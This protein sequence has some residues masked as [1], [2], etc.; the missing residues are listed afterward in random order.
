MA[1]MGASGN[2]EWKIKLGSD[3]LIALRNIE[4]C[5]D[6]TQILPVEADSDLRSVCEVEGAARHNMIDMPDAVISP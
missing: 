4:Y 5:P 3:N 6:R 1:V 2:I